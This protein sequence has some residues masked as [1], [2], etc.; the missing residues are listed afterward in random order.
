MV[1]V[2]CMCS[3]PSLVFLLTR[4]GLKPLTPNRVRFFFGVSHHLVD[5]LVE[6]ALQVSHDSREH[7]AGVD[8]AQEDPEGDGERQIHGGRQDHLEG[9]KHERSRFHG[10][11]QLA[12][13]C[14]FLT[15][16]LSI[17]T[18]PSN[19]LF[20]RSYYYYEP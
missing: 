18:F 14:Y 6:A 12:A 3:C 4:I 10:D 13:Y 17:C 1:K 2:R 8:E 16:S 15:H 11:L 19:Y 9:V 5:F 7:V 20:F